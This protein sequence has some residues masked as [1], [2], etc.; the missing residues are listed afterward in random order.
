MTTTGLFM[1][2]ALRLGRLL[3]LLL[4]GLW[5]WPHPVL[6]GSPDW[7]TGFY[8]LNPSREPAFTAEQN[9]EEERRRVERSRP[10]AEPPPVRPDFRK[11]PPPPPREWPEDRE[12]ADSR[13]YD[14]RPWGDVPPEWRNEDLDRRVPREGYTGNRPAA[15]YRD[16][17]D[18][19]AWPEGGLRSDRNPWEY[20]YAPDRDYR[21]RDFYPS[22]PYYYDDRFGSRPYRRRLPSY[23][24][25]GGD[26]WWDAP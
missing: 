14:N 20:P 1:R 15:R 24:Y 5:W 4:G 9:R 16:F 26:G 12:P 22:S 13:R 25:D 10:Q 18:D 21:R 3:V 8:R 17:P 11:A 19:S 7:G 6:A 23:Y 2:V